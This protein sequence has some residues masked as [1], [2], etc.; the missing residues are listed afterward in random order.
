[1]ITYQTGFDLIDWESLLKLYTVTDGVIG[2]ARKNE[3]ER[4]K[5]AFA[6][7]Y[8]IV[9]AWEGQDIVGAGRMISDGE[10]Y[11]W[12]HDVAVHPDN[13]RQNIGRG[14]M[15]HLLNDE[16]LLVGLTSSFEAVEFYDALGFKKHK[17]AMAKYPGPSSYLE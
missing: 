16:K 8:K 12:V 4:I 13:R 14:I 9:T 11:G 10:C 3:N 2:L 1:M 7:S 17:T 5:R 6:N 15:E